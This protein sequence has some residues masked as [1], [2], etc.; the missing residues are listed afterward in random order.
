MHEQLQ[1]AYA[2]AIAGVRI[3]AAAAMR[4]ALELAGDDEA[5]V[6]Q[7]EVRLCYGAEHRP[8][9][10]MHFDDLFQEI[11]GFFGSGQSLQ[12]ADGQ[13]N[14]RRGFAAKRRIEQRLTK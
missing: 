4:A 11:V 1:G 12:T 5:V 13:M 3:F 2:I 7:S 6:L 10:T 9:T 8:V 14:R